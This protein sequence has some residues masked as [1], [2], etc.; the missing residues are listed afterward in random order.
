MYGT[1]RSPS[2]ENGTEVSLSNFMGTCFTCKKKGHEA[3]QCPKKKAKNPN[4][5]AV[6][7][8]VCCHCGKRVI[9]NPVVG[10]NL[11]IRTRHQLGC[12]VNWNQMK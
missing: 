3:S 4:H 2:E 11:K 9:M 12:V 7:A 6:K 8:T 10:L 1:N 5:G